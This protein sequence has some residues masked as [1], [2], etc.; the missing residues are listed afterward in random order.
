MRKTEFKRRK[1]GLVRKDGRVPPGPLPFQ[2][3]VTMAPEAGFHTLSNPISALMAFIYG[4]PSSFVS[5]GVSNLV[6]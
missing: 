6:F 1:T 2:S 3:L 4:S 5:V